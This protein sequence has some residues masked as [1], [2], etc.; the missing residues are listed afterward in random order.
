[1]TSGFGD[2]I[3]GIGL[4]FA[5][6]SSN[7]KKEELFSGSLFGVQKIDPVRENSRLVGCCTF[8][9]PPGF[10]CKI[11]HICRQNYFNYSHGNFGGNGIIHFGVIEAN[12]LA[13][14]DSIFTRMDIC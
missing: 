12:E 5:N 2:F 7:Q 6:L 14:K 13:Q 3:L 11:S 9:H 1:M 4:R 8:L 10:P